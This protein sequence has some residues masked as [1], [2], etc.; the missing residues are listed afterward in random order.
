MEIL[1]ASHIGK[2]YQEGNNKLHVLTDI[3]LQVSEGELVSITGQSGCGKSTLLHVLGLLDDADSGE[4]FFKSTKLTAKDKRSVEY[5][6]N[7]IGF[8][9]QYHYLLEDLTAEE[10]VALPLLIQGVSYPKSM[11]TAREWLKMLDMIDRKSHYPNALSG[12][13]QQRIAIGRAMIHKPDIVFADEPTG[14]LDPLH[15]NE[16]L[17][18]ML[19]MQNQH[20]QT[21]IL[22]THN[23]DIADKAPKQMKLEQGILNPNK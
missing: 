17:E 11:E 19:K 3:N 12:G 18:I 22:V 9:F 21:C 15:S 20:G 13:E 16:V 6:R 14:N 10:N 1:S 4:L 23:H 5:R 2:S 7:H 8:I